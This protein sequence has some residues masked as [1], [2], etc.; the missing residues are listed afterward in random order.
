MTG[1]YLAELQAASQRAKVNAEIAERY[2][3]AAHDEADGIEANTKAQIG[4]GYALLS[5]ANQL[6]AGVTTYESG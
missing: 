5:I 3:G 4:I 1:D 2:L 6:R